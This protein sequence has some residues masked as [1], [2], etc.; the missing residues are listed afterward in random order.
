[1]IYSGLASHTFRLLNLILFVSIQVPVCAQGILNNGASIVLNNGVTV[2]I[3]GTTGH[4][5]SQNSGLIKNNTSGG[6]IE[7]LGNWVNNST[8]IAFQ[9]DGTT[10]KLSGANQTIGGSYSTSFYNLTLSGSGTK[11]VSVSSITVGGQSSYSGVLSLGARPLDLNGNRLNISNSSTTAITYSSGYVISETNAAINPSIINWKT[12]TNTG[13]YVFPFGVAGSQIPVTFSITSAMAGSTDNVSISTRATTTS[14]NSPWAGVS[15][16]PAVSTM[17]NL[18]SGTDGSLM[19]I[20]RWWNIMPSTAVTANVTFRYRASENTLSAPFNTDNIGAQHW[21]GTN[22]ESTI[23]AATAVTSG[24]GA[25]TANGLTSFSPYVL[26]AS[27]SPLPVELLNFDYVCKGKNIVF[28]WCT[29]TEMNNDYFTL[30]SSSDAIHFKP[31]T[32]IPGEGNSITK[33]QYRFLLEKKEPGHTYFKLSQTDFNGTTKSFNLIH[34]DDCVSPD[35][36]IT[37]N[38]SSLNQLEINI[39]SQGNNYYELYINNI[40]GQRFINEDVQVV[41]GTNSLNYNLAGLTTGIYYVRLYNKEQC[42]IKKI[43]IH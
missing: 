6:N 13:S 34:A 9:N 29:A 41:A 21:N 24:I 4:Y 5:T 18:A 22:W 7:M 2:Y 39:N 37:I 28:N 27:L 19:V 32:T 20:D 38:N 40:L 36:V 35:D 33:K 12:G 26:S 1:M 11:T 15:N 43:L 31:I 30:W 23:G 17:K 16:V 8:T 14:D 3:N 25:V 10:V 42:I